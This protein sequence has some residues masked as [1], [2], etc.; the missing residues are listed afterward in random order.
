MSSLHLVSSFVMHVWITSFPSILAL[1]SI[2]HHSPNLNCWSPWSPSRSRQ[3]LFAWLF[4]LKHVSKPFTHVISHVEIKIMREFSLKIGD[5]NS[6]D[7]LV[8]PLCKISVVALQ[9]YFKFKF[10]RCFSHFS[11]FEWGLS[12]KLWS[13]CYLWTHYST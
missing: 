8:A 12:D 5:F 6:R 9:E 4:L 11:H 2:Y 7:I 13:W 10:W 3:H 1:S